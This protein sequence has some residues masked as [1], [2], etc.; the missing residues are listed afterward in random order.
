MTRTARFFFVV[1][2]A[3]LLAAA[4][5]LGGFPIPALAALLFGAFWTVGLARRWTW[6]PALGL[7]GVYG[8][9]VAGML[10]GLA[11]LLPSA[12]AF[13]ALLAWDLSD[14][15]FRLRLAAPDDDT[16]GLECRHLVRALVVAVIGA[17]V[18]VAAQTLRLE[19]S[20]EWLAVLLLF[21]VWGVGRIIGGLLKR[22]K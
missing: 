11:P 6:I 20:F 9:T 8:L 15:Y 1:L 10:L 18:L 2:S 21:A 22:E 13:A 4:Y 16:S 14:F 19:F 7:F 5:F 3:G 17:A 12:A